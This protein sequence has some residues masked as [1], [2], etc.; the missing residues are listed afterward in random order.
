MPPRTSD[1]SQIRELERGLARLLINTQQ[2]Q[3]LKFI[4][5]SNPCFCNPSNSLPTTEMI[6]SPVLLFLGQDIQANGQCR[7][8]ITR[9]RQKCKKNLQTLSSPVIFIKLCSL[10]L[11]SQ[12]GLSARRDQWEGVWLL[13]NQSRSTFISFTYQPFHRILVGESVLLLLKKVKIH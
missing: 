2:R 1:R 13:L 3:T 5:N 10:T 4:S 12:E 9:G 8:N 6:N 7:A 11:C